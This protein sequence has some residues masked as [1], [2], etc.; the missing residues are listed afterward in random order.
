M[1]E[2]RTLRI[3]LLGA[4]SVGAQ[5]ADQIL[6]HGE[7]LAARIGAGIELIGVA[8]RD[9]KAKRDAAIPANLITTDADRLV[10]EADIVIELMGGIEPARTLILSAIN[11][12]ADIVTANKALLANHA[13]RSS[14]RPPRSARRSTTRPPSAA[15]S[16]SSVRSA[17]RL[18]ATA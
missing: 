2:Y 9:P 7:E 8:V 12:G 18:P 11:S 3:A 17:N 10:R 5:V 1:I 13:P 4:G 14:R 15:P 6:N 16:P